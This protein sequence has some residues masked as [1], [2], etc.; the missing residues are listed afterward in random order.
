[1]AGHL[2]SINTENIVCS[3]EITFQSGK[4]LGSD[5]MQYPGT[6]RVEPSTSFLLLLLF[7]CFIPPIWL[8]RA[9]Q[10]DK[11]AQTLLP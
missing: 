2:N 4:L 7:L 1:M 10:K 11:T 8:S 9:R 6:E 3:P 5:A